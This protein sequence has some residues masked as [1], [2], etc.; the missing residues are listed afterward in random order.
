[1]RSYIF[2]IASLTPTLD[3]NPPGRYCPS[4]FCVIS[5]APRFSASGGKRGRWRN[6]SLFPIGYPYLRK[7]VEGLEPQLTVF[8]TAASSSWATRAQFGSPTRG[9]SLLP[10][11]YLESSP[12][13]GAMLPITPQDFIARAGFE[14]ATSSFRAMR[15]TNSSTRQ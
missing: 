7:R 2:Y 12:S 13:K 5:T 8:E 14:P 4:Y 10:E 15:L 9:R 6:R 1:M 3:I 11:G